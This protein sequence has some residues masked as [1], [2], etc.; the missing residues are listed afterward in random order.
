MP[1]LQPLVEFNGTFAEMI[2]L[3]P[4]APVE[5]LAYPMLVEGLLFLLI[6][7]VITVLSFALDEGGKDAA[8]TFLT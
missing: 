2:Y 4:L 5:L 3:N 7:F 8:L 6:C 1:F